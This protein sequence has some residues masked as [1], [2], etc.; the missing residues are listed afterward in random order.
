MFDLQQERWNAKPRDRI[1]WIPKCEGQRWKVSIHTKLSLGKVGN[2]YIWSL[3]ETYL[4]KE[5][6][7]IQCVSET[8][9]TFGYLFSLPLKIKAGLKDVQFVF[10][11]F[12][13]LFFYLIC[14]TYIFCAVLCDHLACINIF[15]WINIFL[16][17]SK[18]VNY[19]G[20][21]FLQ[22]L[23]LI[24]CDRHSVFKPGELLILYPNAVFLIFKGTFKWQACF[25]LQYYYW[26]PPTM[27]VEISCHKTKAIQ[28]L[29]QTVLSCD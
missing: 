19:I 16:F 7:D 3:E 8:T 25:I 17:I 10:C 24:T 4:N 11:V 20:Y 14:V 5:R 28:F 22:I 12:I 6:K 26:Q 29:W 21:S 13:A 23:L 9:C 27:W 18:T 2:W 1:C 15:F